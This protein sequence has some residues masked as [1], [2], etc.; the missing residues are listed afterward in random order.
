MSLHLRLRAPA[1]GLIAALVVLACGEAASP[2]DAGQ[3]SD[4]G[5]TI[6]GGEP[7]DAGSTDLGAAIDSGA[8]DLGP[9]DADPSDAEPDAT[10]DGGVGDDG[11]TIDDVGAEADTGIEDDAG[12]AQDS[13]A[14]AG[15]GSDAGGPTDAGLGLLCAAYQSPSNEGALGNAN[16]IEL[17]GL[18]TSRVH[19]EVLYAH[20]DSGGTP[21]VF[22]LRSDGADLGEVVLT[23][24]SATDWEDL[25]WGP[26]PG[27]PS[28]YIGDIGDNGLN[29]PEPYLVYRITEPNIP[30]TAAPST[31]TTSYEVF[32]LEYPGGAH[33]NAETL[34]VHPTTGD[35]YIVTKVDA[36]NMSEVY[37]A[38]APLVAGAVH[39]LSWVAALALPAGFDL[40]ITAGDIHP[41]GE[42][43]LLRTYN[44]AYQLVRPSG[45]DFDPIFTAPFV[46]VPVPPLGLG[47]N[48]EIQGEAIAWFPDGL[49]YYTASER[50]NQQ[51]HAVRCQ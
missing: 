31:S 16:L 23:G 8:V 40:P 50:T 49:G 19:P 43:L 27:G 45:P 28:L 24:A 18:V 11:G 20:N 36:G 39:P 3:V 2:L 1:L 48:N 46:R 34:L 12:T 51:L 44:T 4:L 15:S 29:R 10:V 5:A 38:T 41:A 47:P 42:A 7:S 14:D 25:A 21:V 17:S 30:A 26:G 35:L 13:G 6:D 37:K 22:V 32:E 33:H 9:P